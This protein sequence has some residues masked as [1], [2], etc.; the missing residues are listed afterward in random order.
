MARITGFAFANKSSIS[1]SGIC[2][3]ITVSRKRDTLRIYRQIDDY[4]KEEIKVFKIED[5]EKGF[6][7]FDIR[8]KY[9]NIYKLRNII[10]DKIN[11]EFDQNYSSFD[12]IKENSRERGRILE[13]WHQYFNSPKIINNSY[14]AYYYLENTG[15]LWL[16]DTVPA[17]RNFSRVDELSKM[18]LPGTTVTYNIYSEREKEEIYYKKFHIPELLTGTFELSD[19]FLEDQF[20]YHIG[21]NVKGQFVWGIFSDR[22]P[23][24]KPHIAKAINIHPKSLI[25]K[26]KPDITN[27]HD[28]KNFQEVFYFNDIP[29]TIPFS[30]LMSSNLKV[31]KI[32][33]DN[34]NPN[35]FNYLSFHTKEFKAE[36]FPKTFSIIYPYK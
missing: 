6:Y 30:E 19:T 33:I 5:M 23:K 14:K 28:L 7:N 34:D 11:D 12:D 16:Y 8:S 21:L 29:P 18:P 4:K 17:I 10:K 1:T 3:Q 27:L 2:L 9:R 26:I 13:L 36:N 24:D 32:K 15:K 22:P 25:C 31:S 35:D 20:L